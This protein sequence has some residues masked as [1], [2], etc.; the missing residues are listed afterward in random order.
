M[1]QEVPTRSFLL[2]PFCRPFAIAQVL[3]NIEYRH[4][5]PEEQPRFETQRSKRMACKR[6]YAMCSWVS[7]GNPSDG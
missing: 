3:R 6:H 4:A 1:K 5:W 7:L 2:G